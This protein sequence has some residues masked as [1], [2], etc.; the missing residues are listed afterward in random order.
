MTDIW[1]IEHV[2]YHFPQS[3]FPESQVAEF[4]SFAYE[5]IKKY[6]KAKL[7]LGIKFI[8]FVPIDKDVRKASL[9]SSAPIQINRATFH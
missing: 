6:H 4:F 2:C 9:K 3:F 5:I 7:F 8:Y 1:V